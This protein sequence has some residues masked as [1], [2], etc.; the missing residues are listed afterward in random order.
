MASLWLSSLLTKL[1]GL[2]GSQPWESGAEIHMCGGHMELVQLS[3]VSQE[4]PHLGP[5]HQT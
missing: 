3:G 4:H 1:G 2:W 5:D